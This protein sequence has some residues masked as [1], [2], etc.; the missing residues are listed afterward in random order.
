MTKD[1]W[2]RLDRQRR[3]W[4]A[5][6]QALTYRNITLSINSRKPGTKRRRGEKLLESIT[7]S[8]ENIMA[9]LR[10]RD[11]GDLSPEGIL[12]AFMQ[13]FLGE[14]LAR[15]GPGKGIAGEGSAEGAIIFRDDE[16]LPCIEELP[17]IGMNAGPG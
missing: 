10:I 2:D 16:G 3:K 6:L 9:T 7:M 11:E 14:D 12:Y 5:H 15:L 1:E 17:R 8:Q 4:Q 13:W